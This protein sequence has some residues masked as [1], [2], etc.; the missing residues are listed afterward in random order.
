MRCHRDCWLVRI[1]NMLYYYMHDC[2]SCVVCYF[3]DT[4]FFFCATANHVGNDEPFWSRRHPQHVE[5]DLEHPLL[6]RG[7]HRP[8]LVPLQRLLQAQVLDGSFVYCLV[9]CPQSSWDLKHSDLMVILLAARR[10]SSGVGHS[11]SL[12]SLLLLLVLPTTISTP[13]IPP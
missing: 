9:Y 8:H 11:S 10:G 13:M 2:D 4:A 7:R 3:G 1:S 12:A 6:F 5:C